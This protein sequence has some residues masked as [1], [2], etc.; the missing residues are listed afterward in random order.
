MQFATPIIP[1]DPG[2]YVEIQFDQFKLMGRSIAGV[3]TVLTIPGWDLTLDTGRAPDFAFAMNNLAISHWHLDHA[4]G[5]PF[6]LGLRRL[7][8]LPPLNVIV[9]TQKLAATSAFLETLKNVSD[10]GIA[11]HVTSAEKPLTL[12]KGF[13]LEAIPTFHNVPAT[14]YL[15]SQKKNHLKKEF[16]GCPESQ[17]K[18]S[19]L[20]GIEVSETTT[21]PMLAFSGDSMAEFLDTEAGKTPYLVMECSFFGDR[22]EYE[23]VRH[24]GHTHILDWKDRAEK[25]LSHTVIMIHTSQRYSKQQVAEAC[26]KHLPKTLLDRLIIFR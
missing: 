15:V 25:I 12:K 8:S 26:Q 6:Y 23:K 3:E 17:I 18:A 2:V 1:A 10:T 9:P 16:Q 24:Y 22:S 13:M 21:E 7:N 19:S 4:G 5:L 14:G 20:K 11:Y